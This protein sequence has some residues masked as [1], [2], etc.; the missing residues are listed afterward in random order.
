MV[1]SRK[2]SR[3]EQYKVP[4]E[5]YGENRSHCKECE[6][7]SASNRMRRYG[8]TLRGKAS[9]ALQSSR[10]TIRMNGYD[11][12]DDL[13]LIDVI[14]T[15]AHAS[16]ECSYC[17]NVTSD[18]QMEHIVPLSSGGPNTFSNLTVSC[19]PCNKSKH[20]RDLLEWREFK[21]VAAVIDGLA[22]R[23]GCSIAEVLE[24]FRNE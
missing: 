14:F 10:K 19:G 7:T 3:C 20:N 12:L 4:S 16:G 1:E 18:Y 9:R 17:G 6:R 23:R 13:T 15:F 5:F 2:C 8:A 11:V 21:E 22:S 24:E